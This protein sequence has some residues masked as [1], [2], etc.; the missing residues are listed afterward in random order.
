MNTLSESS[1]EFSNR[2]S[3]IVLIIVG[4]IA[5]ANAFIF[6]ISDNPPGILLLLGGSLT[7]LFAFLR[8]RGETRNLR[9][10]W[11]FLYW[12]PRILSIVFAAFISIFA[13][14]VFSEDRGFWE[15][16]ADLLLHLVPTFV[17]VGVLVI[18]W[19][20]EWIAG[21]LYTIL[22]LVYV[23]FAWNKGP[24][25]TILLIAG[26]LVLTGA[27]FLQN[28]KYRAQIRSGSQV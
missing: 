4:L 21:I 27:L 2:R 26:P 18:S 6:G 17:L 12:A 5:I 28:C 25:T 16:S 7:L 19:R 9:T 3:T 22:G 24:L 15:T 20:R 8:R 14:D 23:V 10:V 1:L 11:Q 13:L